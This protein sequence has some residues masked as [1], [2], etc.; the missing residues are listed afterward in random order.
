MTGEQPTYRDLWLRIRGELPRHGRGTDEV[1]GQ[2]KL[3]AELEGALQSLYSNYEQYFE[4]WQSNTDAQA[5]GLTPPVF[6]VVCNNTN[7]SKMVYQYIAG[8]EKKIGDKTVVQAGALDIF[9]NDDGHGSW[10]QRP[11]A[12]LIDSEQLESGEAMSDTFKKI[13]T[14]EIEEFKAEYRL[15]F[16]GRDA[17]DLTDED[18][19]REVI[20]GRQARQIRGAREMRRQRFHA[21]RG[22]GR[23][24]CDACARRARVRHATSVRAGCWSGAAPH[25]LRGG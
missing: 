24:N 19:L 14:R 15:R 10:L 1:T 5:K 25:E 23:Q 21:H 2:P 20:H 12:I 9:R 3:P 4:R 13:A 22:L 18:L 17:E 8:W 16:P 6:I 11:N 7:V